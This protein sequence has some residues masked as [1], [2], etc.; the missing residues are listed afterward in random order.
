MCCILGLAIILTSVVRKQ[1]RPEEA[2]DKQAFLNW[3]VAPGIISFLLLI[4]FLFS[5]S[6]VQESYKF[7]R[8]R[9][10]VSSK[11][12]GGGM[13]SNTL[14]HLKGDKYEDYAGLRIFWDESQLRGSTITY[15]FEQGLLGIRVMSDWGIH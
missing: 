11:H 5:Y 7:S 14:I 15:T 2:K 8:S 13:R 12:G 4:N 10:Y 9:E 6:P 3:C 1:L